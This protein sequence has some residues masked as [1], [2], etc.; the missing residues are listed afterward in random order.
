MILKII[1]TQNKKVIENKCMPQGCWDLV[2]K[3]WSLKHVLLYGA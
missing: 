2:L 1:V 3:A